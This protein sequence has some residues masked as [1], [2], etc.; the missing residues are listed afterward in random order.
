L[1]YLRGNLH[2]LPASP[3]ALLRSSLLSMRGKLRF[4]REPFVRAPAAS[5]DESVF[6]FGARR[7]G[8]E[9]A[10]NLV[11]PAVIGIY[12]TDADALSMQSAFPRI[13][14]LEREHGSVLRGAIAHGRRSGAGQP[15]S[16]PEGLAELPQAL[17]ARLGSRL[18]TAD[19][20]TLSRHPDGWRVGLASGNPREISAD[21]VVVAA[22]AGPSATL[23]EPL[24]PSAARAL[25]GIPYAPAA[26]V[27]LGFRNVSSPLGMD[28]DAYGFIAARGEGI[29][30]LGCQYE[31]SVFADRAPPGGVLLRA[32]LGGTFDP[33]IVEKSDEIIVAQTLGDL[34]RVTGLQRDP[35]FT[36]VWRHLAAFPQYRQGHARQVATADADLARFPNLFVLG[37][38]LRGVGLNPCIAAAA[39]LAQRL[40]SIQA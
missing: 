2:A 26:V 39:A 13:A 7:F 8:Q 11:S 29:A 38:T 32:I 5:D 18:I 36:L 12:A 19:A 35:D 14:A 17:A 9:A 21:A 37:Q 28:L 4:L 33:G 24:A 23:L 16:F 40:S 31:S 34:R 20:T 3:P 1:I 30:L 27:C 15:I 10:R 25:R 6:A 22:A